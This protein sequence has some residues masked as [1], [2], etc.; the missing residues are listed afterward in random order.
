[1]G[2]ERVL[3]VVGLEYFAVAEAASTGTIVLDTP[4]NLAA[5][6]NR[7]YMMIS[8]TAAVDPDAAIGFIS[9]GA[10]ASVNRGRIVMENIPVKLFGPESVSLILESGASG[11]LVFQNFKLGLPRPGE[12]V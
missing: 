12:G 9:R 1:M 3:D 8:Y 6:P 2:R 11:I 4:F 10:T 7:A 5:D